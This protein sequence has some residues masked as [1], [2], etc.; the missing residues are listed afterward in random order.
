[1]AYPLKWL[2]SKEARVLLLHRMQLTWDSTW[3]QMW[4]SLSILH[5]EA[6]FHL[7]LC[8]PNVLVCQVHAD[9][10]TIISTFS[11]DMLPAYLHQK[12]PSTKAQAHF[13]KCIVYPQLWREAF[14]S[15]GS[16]DVECQPLN[17]SEEDGPTVKCYVSVKIDDNTKVA[18]VPLQPNPMK[19]F[20]NRKAI[21][22]PVCCTTYSGGQKQR[23]FDHFKAA[24]SQLPDDKRRR[25]EGLLK[26]M[27]PEWGTKLPKKTCIRCG[28]LVARS[29][30]KH[31]QS[32][33]CKL[34]EHT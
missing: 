15:A 20:R 11:P 27:F 12:I 22:C 18:K 10:S 1:M 29:M 13:N 21:I 26:A 2:S 7:A 24:H 5:Q 23:L 34:P 32:S 17:A 19:K 3:A 8:I 30:N 9:L 14:E 16:I 25:M 4:S 31:Q 6:G 28:K 33:A